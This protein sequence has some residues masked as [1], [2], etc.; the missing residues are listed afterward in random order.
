[1][2]IDEHFCDGHKWNTHAFEPHGGGKTPLIRGTQAM[3]DVADDL[4]TLTPAAITTAAAPAAAGVYTQVDIQAMV[5]LLNEI[6]TVLLA[7]SSG[8]ILTTK[9]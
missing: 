5:D 7:I 1:M 8:T 3:R 6:R 2:Q 4:A 9:V